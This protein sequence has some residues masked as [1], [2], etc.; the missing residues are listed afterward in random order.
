MTL[1]AG[2]GLVQHGAAE[3]DHAS[4]VSIELQ[5]NMKAGRAVCQ[6]KIF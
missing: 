3:R 1:R 5:L 6:L 4:S 2:V